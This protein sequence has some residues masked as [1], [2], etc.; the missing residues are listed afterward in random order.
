MKNKITF[1]ITIIFTFLLITVNIKANETELLW[2]DEF[3]KILE[4]NEKESHPL[5]EKLRQKLSDIRV[6]SEATYVYALVPANKDDANSPFMLTVD[7]SEEAEEWGITYNYEVQFSEAWN[8]KVSTARS[9]WKDGDSHQ[10]SAFAPI[11][12]SNKKIVALL[13]LD[14]PVTELIELYPEWSR[15][16]ETWNGYTDEITGD[17]PEEIKE[18]I[19]ILKFLVEGYSTIL[20]Y[21]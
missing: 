2:G 8:G 17:I 19:E 14:Y 4:S 6:E 10:W 13:G 12:D 18:N 21:R 5:Y 9:A 1:F 7:G 16:S 3:V 20:N 11:Y 15:D